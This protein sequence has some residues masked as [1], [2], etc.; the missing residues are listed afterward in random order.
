MA[1]DEFQTLPGVGPSIAA[2]FRLLG[3]KSLKDLARRDP[4]RL[5]TRLCDITHEKQDPCVLYVFR[6]AVYASRTALPDR[7]LLEWPAWMTRKFDARGKVVTTE[8]GVPLKY[9]RTK[10]D[11]RRLRREHGLSS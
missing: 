7:Q 11:V 6:C 4:E 9:R 1:R 10:E 5:Y 3:V 2:D 8:K